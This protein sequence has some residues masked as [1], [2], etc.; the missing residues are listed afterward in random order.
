MHTK[1]N[2]CFAHN[3]TDAFSSQTNNLTSGIRMFINSFIITNT[4]KCVRGTNN[5]TKYANRTI[6]IIIRPVGFYIF[7]TQMHTLKRNH[8][9]IRQQQ[10]FEDLRGI[11]C[12]AEEVATLLPSW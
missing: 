8:M 6:F 5:R 7:T 4:H 11:G 3:Y 12:G 10:R 1:F 2:I 9:Q